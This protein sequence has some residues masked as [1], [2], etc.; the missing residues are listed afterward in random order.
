M[1]ERFFWPATAVAEAGGREET[2]SQCIVP[3]HLSQDLDHAPSQH[4]ARVGVGKTL[5]RRVDLLEV[6]QRLDVAL[7]GVRSPP[8]IREVVALQSTGMAEQMAHREHLRRVLITQSKVREVRPHGRVKVKPAL[9][10]KLQ[11]K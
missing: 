9:I 7:D 4:V 6:R 8:E 2:R 1:R 3:G 10:N 11:C 5:P